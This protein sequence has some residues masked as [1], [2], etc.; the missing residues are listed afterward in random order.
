MLNIELK[1]Y[2]HSGMEALCRLFPIKRD[3]KA[4]LKKPSPVPL[5]M[6]KNKAVKIMFYCIYDQLLLQ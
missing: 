2:L 4:E 3:W 5:C 6:K 1:L